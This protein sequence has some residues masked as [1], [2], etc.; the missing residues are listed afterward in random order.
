MFFSHDVDRTNTIIKNGIIIEQLVD[1]KYKLENL[2]LS[3][4]NDKEIEKIYNSIKLYISK[5]CIHNITNDYIDI[6][7]D[8]SL[9]IKYCE[10]CLETFS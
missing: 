1:I 10:K 2:L 7:C 3:T 5:N 4:S 6:E 8:R 9:K